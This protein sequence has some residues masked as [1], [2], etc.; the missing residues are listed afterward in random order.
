MDPRKGRQKGGTD[1]G[2]HQ[3]AELPGRVCRGQQEAL[4]IPES[5]CKRRGSQVWLNVPV[6]P[7]FGK[8]RQKDS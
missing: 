8:L 7:G 3:G 1:Q 4:G 2:Q 5:S 6:I